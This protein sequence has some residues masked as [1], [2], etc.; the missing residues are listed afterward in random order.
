MKLHRILLVAGLAA[1]ASGC[2]NLT[3]VF[4]QFELEQGKSI[5][6]DA[7]QRTILVTK[8]RD[9][10]GG[11]ERMVYCAEPSPDSHF[12]VGS[13]VKGSGDVTLK[14]GDKG[15]VDYGQNLNS[16]ASDALSARNATIQ[17]LRDGLYRACEAHASG[18][19][20][21]LEYAEITSRYQKMVLA[22][23][24]F[25]LV[26]NLNRPRR[27]PSITTA[28]GGLLAEDPGPAPAAK[29]APAEK[30]A[31][32]VKKAA[33]L[34]G[35][36]AGG[37]AQAQTFYSD[38]A[39]DKI[40]KI[41]VELVS[42]VLKSDDPVSQCLRYLSQMTYQRGRSFAASSRNVMEDVC[43]NIVSRHALPPA[44]K[45]DTALK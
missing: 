43:A 32:D 40:S 20:T 39:I 7:Q 11:G 28:N 34:L 2:A 42:V 24:S 17:L 13:A 35:A 15:S 10:Y 29:P 16:T 5:S 45:V 4:R 9:E 6:I 18:A 33:V 30:P 27:D 38:Q 41:A 12:A 3:T 23:L 19:L 1:L 25:E 22:L 44:V 8:V 21:R 37:S 26:S 31:P 14:S 36:A